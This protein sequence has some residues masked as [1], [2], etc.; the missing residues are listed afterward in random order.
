MQQTASTLM[1]MIA[2]GGGSCGPQ[3]IFGRSDFV[4]FSARQ[5][6]S[7]PELCDRYNP[8]IAIITLGAHIADEGDFYDM[9]RRVTTYLDS[10]KDRGLQLPKL[11][12]KSQNPPHLLCSQFL[13]PI[14]RFD[15]DTTAE[16][17]YKF[18]MLY[19]LDKVHQHLLPNIP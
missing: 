15:V 19:A 18:K 6:H 2:V 7:F 17:K 1:S 14:A 10:R 9:H 5:Q 13:S 12:F 11:V 8:Q 16:D 4:G 3:I